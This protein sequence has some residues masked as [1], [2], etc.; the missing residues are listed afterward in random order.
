MT[1]LQ[2]LLLWGLPLMLV[3]VVIHLLNRMRYRTQRWAATSFLMAASR[4]SQRQAKLRH[5]L[6][7]LC[8]ALLVGAL[9]FALARPLAGGWLGWA[10]NRAPDTVLLLVDRS[11]SME[12]RAG[13]GPLTKRQIALRQL[14]AAAEALGDQTRF[15]LV[16]SSGLVPREAPSAAAL[17]DWS[18]TAP[19]DVAA[20]IPAMLETAAA[21]IAQTQPGRTEIWLASDL[22]QSNWRPDSVRWTSVAARLSALPQ[23]PHVRLLGLSQTPTG[24][25]AVSVAAVRLRRAATGGSPSTVVESPS[26]ISLDLALDFRR[27]GDAPAA[28][29]V[30]LMVNGARTQFGLELPGRVVRT[31][32]VVGVG[33]DPAPGWGWAELPADTNER[34]NRG[35]FAFN[36]SVPLRGVVV[37]DDARLGRLLGLAVAPIAGRADRSCARI[38]PAEFDA[39]DLADIALVVWAGPERDPPGP[40]LKRLTEFAAAGG[41]IVTFPAPAGADPE[42]APADQP[43]RVT[44]WRRNEGPLANTADGTEL[45]VA[46]LLVRRRVPLGPQTTSLAAFVDGSSFLGRET[47][48][49][50]AH[51][52]CAA[53]PLPEWSDLAEGLVLVPML[54]RLLVE[55]AARLSGAD[56]VFCGD[57]VGAGADGIWQR[58]DQETARSAVSPA[59]TDAEHGTRAPEVAGVY[60]VANRVFAVNRSPAEDAPEILDEPRAVELFGTVPVR[61]FTQQEQSQQRLQGEIWRSFLWLMLALLVVEGWLAKPSATVRGWG[62]GD[63]VPQERGPSLPGDQAEPGAIGPQLRGAAEGGA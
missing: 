27:S 41:V 39:Y 13:S 32:K 31:H 16:D 28:A 18:L 29:P 58:L 23:P 19:T 60:R 35:Y 10:L 22:Q 45:P 50:G 59:R 17:A 55:G 40:A 49:T 25:R 56:I 54:Q 4:Q 38:T 1:F 5:L 21:Y 11:P 48:G 37:T 12:I 2:P 26:P 7:L 24:N 52:W 42:I 61:L 3:P 9:V 53:L 30:T 6:L 43:F 51:Y 62:S 63:A 47:I 8:R 44:T 57:P 33:D 46:D 36:P 15:I 14:T 34:D 20:D